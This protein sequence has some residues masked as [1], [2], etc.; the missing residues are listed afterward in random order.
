MTNEIK[1][2]QIAD[3]GTVHAVR[4]RTDTGYSNEF[5]RRTV[6]GRPDP[7]PA[8]F[9]EFVPVDAYLARPRPGRCLECSRRLRREPIETEV[10]PMR[11]FG[12]RWWVVKVL[13]RN[14]KWDDVYETAGEF[15][16]EERTEEQDLADAINYCAG[17]ELPAPRIIRRVND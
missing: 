5:E 13:R 9:A 6:C 4:P 2:T 17:E 3:R 7:S 10:Y 8:E 1:A 12:D 15:T 11:K 16:E 14:G